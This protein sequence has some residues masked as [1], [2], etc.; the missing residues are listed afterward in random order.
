MLHFVSTLLQF[1]VEDLV[2][3]RGERCNYDGVVTLIW[4]T[5]NVFV[6]FCLVI[7]LS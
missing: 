5:V 4:R 1:A 6:V 2:V 3:L 7:V